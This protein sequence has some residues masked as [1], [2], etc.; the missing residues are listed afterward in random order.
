MEGGEC[1]FIDD[2]KIFL[3]AANRSTIPYAMED[4]AEERQL[5]EKTRLAPDERT[6]RRGMRCPRKACEVIFFELP[7][8]DRFRR[9]L[10]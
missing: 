2:V 8:N 9:R 6:R 7:R 10:P 3:D 4:L 1:Q 5:I